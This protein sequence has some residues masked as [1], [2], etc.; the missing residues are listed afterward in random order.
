LF[1]QLASDLESD[2]LIGPSDERDS[3]CG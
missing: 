1:S 2:S 3:L